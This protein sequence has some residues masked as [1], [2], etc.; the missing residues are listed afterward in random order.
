M[1]TTKRKSSHS[2]T[3]RNTRACVRAWEAA[4]KEVAKL[5]RSLKRTKQR[6]KKL[7][8]EITRAALAP[9]VEHHV[10]EWGNKTEINHE[11]GG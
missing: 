1:S 11:M 4:Q 2:R 10:D 6:T 9:V 5:K 3:K 8:A 7:E